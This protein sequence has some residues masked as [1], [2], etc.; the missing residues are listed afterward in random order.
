MLLRNAVREDLPALESLCRSSIGMI[1]GNILPPDILTE[2][3]DGDIVRDT[4]EAQWQEMTVAIVQ[5]MNGMGEVLAGVMRI[6]DGNRVDLL[7]VD[8]DHHRQGIGTALLHHAEKRI[9]CAHPLAWLTVFR[10]N[11]NARAFYA[12]MHWI[13]VEHF[14]DEMG[15]AVIRMEKPL[16]AKS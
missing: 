4:L 16:L 3:I 12:R 14:M 6:E 10:E 8:P 13:E 15:V 9:A 5:E 2:W 1:Y 7:W 11:T